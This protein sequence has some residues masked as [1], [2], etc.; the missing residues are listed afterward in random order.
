MFQLCF[1]GTTAVASI[2][3]RGAI[4]ATRTRQS[5]GQTA[6][7]RSLLAG[8]KALGA[9]ADRTINPVVQKRVDKFVA[10]SRGVDRAGARLKRRALGRPEPPPQLRRQKKATVGT[11]AAL[12]AFETDMDDTVDERLLSPQQRRALMLARRGYHA[13]ATGVFRGF[14]NR[15]ID[16]S[17]RVVSLGVPSSASSTPGDDLAQRKLIAD[18][19]HANDDPETCTESTAPGAASDNDEEGQFKD[20]TFGTNATAAAAAASGHG[21]AYDQLARQLARAVNTKS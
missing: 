16:L 10:L 1:D 6:V 9:R 17:R 18:A 7:T 3:T 5:G 12:D 11:G 14:A 4:T 20:C 8:Q 21:A 15:V 19:H 2:A 13:T